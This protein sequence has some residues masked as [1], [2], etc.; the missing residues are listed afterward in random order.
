VTSTKAINTP[1]NFILIGKTYL[2]LDF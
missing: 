2:H 1:K